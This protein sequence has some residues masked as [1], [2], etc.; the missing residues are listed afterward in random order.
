MGE[1]GYRVEAV[2]HIDDV[3][4]HVP[5]WRRLH[6]R[7]LEDNVFLA[8]EFLVPL[9]RHDAAADPYQ[10]AF[11]YGPDGDMIG[12]AAFAGAP[13]L[14]AV[15]VGEIA[16]WEHEMFLDATPLLD[17]ERGQ[18]AVAALLD[19]LAAAGQPWSL[20]RWSRIAMASVAWAQIAAA[21]DRLGCAWW[22]RRIYRRP[23]LQRRESFDAYLAEL[24]SKRRGRLRWRRNRFAREGE[25][26][27]LVHRDIAA[28]PGM[29]DRFL[30]LEAAGWKGGAGT[31]IRCR[32]SS[33]RF[34]REAMDALG[35]RGALY[36]L[37]MRLDGRPVSIT[38]NLC[39][40]RTLYGFKS[41]FDP[42]L[43]GLSPGIVNALEI[44]ARLH[45][46][47]VL[48]RLDSC[49]EQ[50]CHLEGVWIDSLAVGEVRVATCALGGVA[51]SA[52]PYLQRGRTLASRALGALRRGAA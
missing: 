33:E 2:T 42:E 48:E 41:G 28:D 13:A 32:P 51:L 37:E 24:P 34:F 35:A 15:T 14:V 18:Q 11:V 6:A 23:L 19:W 26:E 9:L 40:G 10:M 3:E 25:L 17:R 1:N 44:A 50:R 38:A 22:P 31:A 20:V 45:E 49:G 21:T 5:A 12:C 39:D 8:P 30:A 47:P 7:R 43:E 52:L 29:L 46:D 36:F 27:V 4:A 16:T